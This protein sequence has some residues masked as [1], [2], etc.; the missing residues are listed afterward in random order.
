MTDTC[1]KQ[2]RSRI[3]AAI[4]SRGNKSTELKLVTILRKYQ[5]NGWRR[6][7]P[8]PGRPDFIFSD[9]HLAVFVDGCFWHGCRWHC[10]MPKSRLNYWKPKIDRNRSRRKQVD[11]LLRKQGWSVL[12]VWEHLLNKPDRV[13]T[14]IQAKLEDRQKSG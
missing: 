13:A 11:K 3:M 1:T 4:S 7:Q 9:E 5:I 8:L 12:R 2:E 14:R 10:R 6:H